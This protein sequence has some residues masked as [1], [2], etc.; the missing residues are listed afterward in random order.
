[1]SLRSRIDSLQRKK[2]SKP[3]YDFHFVIEV[4]PDGTPYDARAFA[5]LADA[6]DAEKAGYSVKIELCTRPLDTDRPWEGLD[7]RL[8]HLMGLEDSE[9]DEA[10]DTPES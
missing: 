5:R 4:R 9:D 8:Q 1:M 2:S 7:K 3:Y 10:R 6:M